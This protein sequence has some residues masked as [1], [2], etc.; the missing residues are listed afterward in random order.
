MELTPEIERQIEKSIDDTGKREIHALKQKIRIAEKSLDFTPNKLDQYKSFLFEKIATNLI[1]MAINAKY[2]E[3][4]RQTITLERMERI[5]REVVDELKLGDYSIFWEKFHERFD[6][7]NEFESLPR[8]ES[9]C[10][11]LKSL[12]EN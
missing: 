12:R 10:N 6:S 7:I 8:M 2:F 3:E 9:G 11:D 1:S 4:Q 5:W